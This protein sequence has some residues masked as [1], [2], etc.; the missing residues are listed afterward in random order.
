VLKSFERLIAMVWMSAY[1]QLLGRTTRKFGSLLAPSPSV[2]LPN[3]T[4]W[5]PSIYS[6]L[7]RT[8][9]RLISIGVLMNAKIRYLQLCQNQDAKSTGKKLGLVAIT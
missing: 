4:F 9:A 6:Q 5:P 2:P 1:G 8:V 7:F 3:A